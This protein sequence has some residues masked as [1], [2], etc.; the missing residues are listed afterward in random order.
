ML[1]FDSVIRLCSS[2]ALFM[3]LVPELIDCIIPGG[4]SEVLSRG[5]DFGGRL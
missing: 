3:P 5:L 1:I 2:L 4:I